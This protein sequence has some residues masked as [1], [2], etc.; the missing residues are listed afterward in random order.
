MHPM[1]AYYRYTTART[2]LY[3][4]IKIKKN[5][6]PLKNKAE[7]GKIKILSNTP[8][9]NLH[10]ENLRGFFQ[11]FCAYLPQII[12]LRMINFHHFFHISVNKRDFIFPFVHFDD[13]K[14]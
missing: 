10:Y 12:F 1:H 6:P 11:T 3:S 14:C 8:L 5:K 13:W 9:V 7:C 4:T 2:L